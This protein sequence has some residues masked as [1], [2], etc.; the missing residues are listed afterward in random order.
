MKNKVLR[1]WFEYLKIPRCI[2]LVY[3]KGD[4]SKIFESQRE[5]SQGFMWM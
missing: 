5:A 3:L 4:K 2:E 1:V